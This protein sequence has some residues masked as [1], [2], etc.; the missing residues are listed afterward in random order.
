MNAPQTTVFTVTINLQSALD[1]IV[2]ATDTT[3]TEQQGANALQNFLTLAHS[4]ADAQ[5][6]YFAIE[7]KAKDTEDK[8]IKNRCSEAKAVFTATE[9]GL[10]VDGMGYHE[11]VKAARAHLKEAGIMPNGKERK[12]EEERLIDKRRRFM[13]QAIKDGVEPEQLAAAWEQEQARSQGVPEATINDAAQDVVDALLSQGFDLKTV[14]KVLKAANA[15][16]Q[17]TEEA[18]ASVG[19]SV[20]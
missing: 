18:G 7:Q 6:V 14:R 8:S 19:E 10:A 3:A 2:K 9:H 20:E 5:A 13:L 12:T 16:L 1:A 4:Q 15:L 11:A 17:K